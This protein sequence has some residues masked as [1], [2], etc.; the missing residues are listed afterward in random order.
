MGSLT[1]LLWRKLPISVRVARWI[2]LAIVCI[3]V[4]LLIAAVLAVTRC[5]SGNQERAQA[6]VEVF[7]DEAF[8]N[9]A[10]D[11]IATQQGAG[12]RERASDELSRN[13]EKEIRD[14]D[15]ANDAV[16]PRVRD[17]GVAS[18][19]KRAAYRDSARCQL[20]EPAAR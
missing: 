12:A 19:C 5:G 2:A 11:A 7:Q 4:A 1:D 13:N 18:L 17:A 10:A 14:A 16:N 8:A 20:R 3:G 6:R 9:S 15:G